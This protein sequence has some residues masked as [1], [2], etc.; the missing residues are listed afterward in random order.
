MR[1]D[2]LDFLSGSEH[3]AAHFVAVRVQR[4]LQKHRPPRKHPTLS[5]THPISQIVKHPFPIPLPPRY[6]RN[7]QRAFSLQHGHRHDRLPHARLDRLPVI[8]LTIPIARSTFTSK[9]SVNRNV[10][11]GVHGVGLAVRV[12]D[13][14]HVDL[15]EHD[16][17]ADAGAALRVLH[18]DELAAAAFGE[19]AE[20][21]DVVVV[22]VLVVFGLR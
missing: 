14:V 8:L 2:G 6:P 12:R 19:V 18:E 4:P 7:S 20:E 16:F 22:I 13:L 17:D 5:P 15:V 3:R 21:C 1:S 10:G 9:R 11:P